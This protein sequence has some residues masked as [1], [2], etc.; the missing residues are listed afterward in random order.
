MSQA[1]SRS[2]HANP[3]HQRVPDDHKRAHQRERARLMNHVPHGRGGAKAGRLHGIEQVVQP[4]HGD[5]QRRQPSDRKP[6]QRRQ[7]DHARAQCPKHQKQNG[8]LERKIEVIGHAHD[9]QFEQHQPDAARQ[10]KHGE[11]FFRMIVS[12]T[13]RHRSR[14]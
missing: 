10:Q 13:E 6:D 12:T 4:D 8:I 9:R 2:H 5:A 14:R 11:F 7:R 1:E 3:R